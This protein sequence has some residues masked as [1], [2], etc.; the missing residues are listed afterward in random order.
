MLKKLLVAAALLIAPAAHAQTWYVEDNY[1]HQCAVFAWNGLTTPY[2]V[3]AWVNA[4]GGIATHEN[5]PMP[6]KKEHASGSTVEIVDIHP[7]AEP[8]FMIPFFS[9]VDDCMTY[10]RSEKAQKDNAPL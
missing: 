6:P 10:A 7:G 3:I 8:E 5:V 1:Q 4:N 2:E 9:S